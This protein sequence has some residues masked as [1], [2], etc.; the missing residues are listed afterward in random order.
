MDNAP[1]WLKTTVAVI[2][3]AV[4]IYGA[5]RPAPTPTEA[6]PEAISYARSNCVAINE[7]KALARELI[8]VSPDDPDASP[9]EIRRFTEKVYV[10]TRPRDCESI[11]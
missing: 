8:A 10:L 1:T 9:E 7:V 2:L 4:A 5:V 6:T 11:D 3:A